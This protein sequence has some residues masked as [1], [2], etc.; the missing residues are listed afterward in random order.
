MTTPIWTPASQILINTG[1]PGFAST[2]PMRFGLND[3]GA[4][5][6]GN[7]TVGQWVTVDMTQWGVPANAL[8]VF[9]TG[10]LIITHGTTAETADIEIGFRASG[11][12]TALPGQYALQCI[13]AAI[14]GGQRSPCSLWVPL[15]NGKFDYIVT[16]FTGGN[17]PTNSA[18]GANFW[19]AAVAMP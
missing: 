7:Q 9:L 2:D 10:L 18:Y 6:W 12:T 4:G 3:A 8:A 19:P 17:W 5:D 13:E 15:A 14:G 1:Q 11:D 16:L